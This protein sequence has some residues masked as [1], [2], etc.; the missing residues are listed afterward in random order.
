MFDAAIELD[1]GMKV[2]S[3]TF[4]IGVQGDCIASL[5]GGEGL[6]DL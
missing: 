5:E 6:I 3:F 4:L 2:G 1:A